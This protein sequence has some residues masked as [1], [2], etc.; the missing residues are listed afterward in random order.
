MAN[1]RNK[2]W[3]WQGKPF[4][5]QPG[6]FITSLDSIA[7]CC[8]QGVTRQNIRTAI[9]RFEKLEF[10]TNI[11]TKTG[12]LIT[13]LNWELYQCEDEKPNKA[14]NK[15][16]TKSQQRPNKQLT[17][18]EES[19]EGKKVKNIYITCQHLS[20]SEEEYAKLVLEYGEI[21]VKSK[22]DYATNYAKLKNYKSLYLTLNNWLKA[23]KEKTDGNTGQ[24]KQNY[25]LDKSK[26]L[27]PKCTDSNLPD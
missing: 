1:F 27:A 13:I 15:D 8:G 22:I 3:E 14:T 11:S 6:Q 10:L 7:K 23:D 25:K 5:C 21:T 20:I 2:K 16:L 4:E 26:F 18:R 24:A 17:P 19:K 12:R 9:E